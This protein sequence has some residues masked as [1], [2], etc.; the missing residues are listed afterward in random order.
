MFKPVATC[1][2]KLFDIKNAFHGNECA[3]ARFLLAAQ[4]IAITPENEIWRVKN[5]FIEKITC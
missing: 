2:F 4:K 1:G 3:A 5:F